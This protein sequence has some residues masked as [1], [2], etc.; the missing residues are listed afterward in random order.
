V[1][2]RQLTVPANNT[3]AECAE[4]VV[5]K[6]IGLDTTFLLTWKK[7]LSNVDITITHPN[8]TESNAMVVKNSADY[9][10]YG[11]CP[12]STVHYPC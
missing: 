10:C 2:T 4:I 1:S 11:E 7:E 6:N 12:V 9:R 3:R 5:D 8:G